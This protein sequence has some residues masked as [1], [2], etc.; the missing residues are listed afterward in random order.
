MGA[1]GRL[2]DGKAKER[3]RART[4][5]WKKNNPGYRAYLAARKAHIKKATPSWADKDLLTAVYSIAGENE[6]DHIIPITHPDVCGLHVPWNLQI[7]SPMDNNMKNNRFDGT[8]END[9]WREYLDVW[10]KH[11]AS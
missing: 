9:S 4:A 8:Y 1:S 2:F 10:K 7:L 6:V 5:A 11:L 3:N